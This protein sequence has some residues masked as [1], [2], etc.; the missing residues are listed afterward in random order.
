[1]PK[2]V[3]NDLI[4]KN[5][6]YNSHGYCLPATKTSNDLKKFYYMPATSYDHEGFEFVA[7]IE[8]KQYPFFG[9]QWHPE[10]PQ[11]EWKSPLIPH[12]FDSIQSGIYFL[13]AFVEMARKNTNRFNLKY[14]DLL[15]YNYQPEYAA[16]YSPFMQIYKFEDFSIDSSS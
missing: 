13:N 5:I 14:L 10:K 6:T 8:A 11:F 2:Q 9:T 15:S 1:M 3:R 7:M 12:N 4:T 16:N